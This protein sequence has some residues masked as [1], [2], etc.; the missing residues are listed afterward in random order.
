MAVKDYYKILGVAKNASDK[1]IKAAYRRLARK[2]HPD[3]NPGNKDSEDRFKEISEANEILSNPDTRK[4]YD[5]YGHLGDGWKNAAEAGQGY[6]NQG[7]AGRGNSQRSAEGFNFNSG[8][9]S[10]ILSD[11]LG[12]GHSNI[13]RGPVKGEDSEYEISVSIQDA[14]R[15]AEHGIT[16]QTQESCQMCSATGYA[17]N[18]TCPACGG[19]GTR[20]TPKKLT[21]KIPKG[22]R[23]GQKIRLQNQGS[24]G[25]MGGQPGD[26]Y[27]IVKLR[28]D[29]HFELVEDDIYSDVNVYYL[30]A[31]LGAEITVHT[32]DGSVNMKIPPGTSSGAKLR[33]RGKGMPKKNSEENGDFYARV[34]IVV[35]K[36]YSES[37]QKL[38]MELQLLSKGNNNDRS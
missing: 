22:I 15:G 38:L 24:P 12:G 34:K 26:L 31:I 8:G 21:V 30:D 23:E 7:G 18:S 5:Q 32:V 16:V 4:K 33:I 3:V 10:D 14:F 36:I 35:P 25:V 1:D 13:R 9:F 6:F 2:H 27:L 20:I 19:R 28:S 37:E 11:L 17:N 29:N